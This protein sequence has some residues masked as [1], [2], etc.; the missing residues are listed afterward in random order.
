M[1]C[2]VFFE[3]F[4]GGVG[5]S[6]CYVEVFVGWFLGFVVVGYLVY[7]WIVFL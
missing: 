2:M 5:E 7:Y 6:V 4:D 3:L 1:F